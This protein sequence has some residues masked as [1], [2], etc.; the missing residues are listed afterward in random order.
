MCGQVREAIGVTLS[1]LCSN[2][3]LHTT[4]TSNHSHG[5]DGF[6]IEERSWD[7]FLVE[8][9]SELVISIQNASHSDKMEI[10]KD[11][12]P[13]NGLVNGESQDDVKWMETVFFYSIFVK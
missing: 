8:R 2:I 6:K 13:D 4:F 9:A 10:Q 7:Q 5:G 1:V 3:R 12:S 11:R